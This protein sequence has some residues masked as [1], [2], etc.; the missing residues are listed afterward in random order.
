MKRV[1]RQQHVWSFDRETPPVISVVPGETLVLE[2]HDARGGT[3]QAETDTLEVPNLRG[4]NPAAGPVYV[5][6]AMPGNA[7]VVAIETI[8]L[9]GQGYTGVKINTG[10]LAGRARV[11]VTRIVHV[12]GDRV[13]FNDRVRFPVRPMVGTVGVAPAGAPVSCLYPGV[14]G[15]NMDNNL[16]TV[17]AKLHL[18][19][20]VE[21]AL[22]AL[23]D[24]HASMGDGEISSVGLDFPAT[25]TVRIDLESEADVERPW[26][27]TK[28]GDWVSTG[29]DPDP[30][31]AMRIAASQMVDLLQG[32]LDISFEDAYMLA[33][34]R[35]DLGICQAADPGK[36]PV[37][38]RFVMPASIVHSRR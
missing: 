19:V 15:G 8:E 26:I 27:E 33:T 5:D 24:V 23:G 31:K 20:F 22:L 30:A 16:V 4:V 11:P 14:H 2:T 21:G 28:D 25:V 34:I 9:G 17:G 6:G 3:I 37:T 38:T 32:R 10:L 35:G 12:E 13:V 7:L 1:S 36:F 29:D 18:P